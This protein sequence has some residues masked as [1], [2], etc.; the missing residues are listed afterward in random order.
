MTKKTLVERIMAILKGGDEAKLARFESKL[1]KYFDKQIAMR[2]EEIETLKDKISDAEE[3]LND[4]I[5]NVSVESINSTDSVEGYCRTYVTSVD[6]K[7][8]VIEDLEERI[9]AREEEITRLEKLR[10]RI[11]AEGAAQA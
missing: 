10:D 11:Y 7:L 9:K 5:V 6:N 8:K 2:R 1:G 4:T 3:A